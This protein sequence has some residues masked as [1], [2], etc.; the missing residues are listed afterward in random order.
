VSIS[1]PLIS[2][3]SKPPAQITNFPESSSKLTKAN[4]HFIINKIKNIILSTV[5]AKFGVRRKNL[6][7]YQ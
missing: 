2:P 4:H 3:R 6:M 7:I 5:S 1:P